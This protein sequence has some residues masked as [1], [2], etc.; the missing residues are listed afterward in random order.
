MIKKVL[1]EIRVDKTWSTEWAGLRF[2]VVAT[3]EKRL[4]FIHWHETFELAGPF[5][6]KQEDKAAAKRLRKRYQ[7]K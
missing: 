4:W 1:K 2:T 6:N 5:N 3:F 7:L